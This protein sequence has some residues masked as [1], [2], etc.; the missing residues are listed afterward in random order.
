MHL[1]C[2]C[3]ESDSQIVV[4]YTVQPLDTLSSTADLLASDVIGMQSLYIICKRES[5]QGLLLLGE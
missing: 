2:G 5:V 1:L 4:T 3:V